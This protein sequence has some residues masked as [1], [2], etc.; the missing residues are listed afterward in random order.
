[1]RSFSAAPNCL[2]SVWIPFGAP[3]PPKA[4]KTPPGNVRFVV[5]NFP[6]NQNEFPGNSGNSP[7][8]KLCSNSFRPGLSRKFPG[9][10]FRFPG[11]K[12]RVSPEKF[13][14][15]SPGSFPGRCNTFPYRWPPGTLPRPDFRYTDFLDRLDPPT[16]PRLKRFASTYSFPN[17]YNTNEFECDTRV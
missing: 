17:D 6:G 9:N 3:G 7:E 4:R 10:F 12:C 5:E 8:K 1:M 15:V 11:K 13:W 2:R 14:N 16:R